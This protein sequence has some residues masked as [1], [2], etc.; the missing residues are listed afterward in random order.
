MKGK[1]EMGCVSAPT[2]QHALVPFSKL[3]FCDLFYD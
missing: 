2:R 1:V 3:P